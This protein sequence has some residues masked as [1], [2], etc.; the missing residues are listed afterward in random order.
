MSV[1]DRAGEKRWDTAGKEASCE[2]PSRAESVTTRASN[3]TDEET[4][5]ALAECIISEHIRTLT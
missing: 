3:Q 4:V 5:R 1:V 2:C